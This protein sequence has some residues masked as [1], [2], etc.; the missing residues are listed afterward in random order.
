MQ[1]SELI[2]RLFINLDPAFFPEGYLAD[3]NIK[4][5]INY[6]MHILYMINQYNPYKYNAILPPQKLD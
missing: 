3:H 4:N 1:G 5:H 6:E 2:I